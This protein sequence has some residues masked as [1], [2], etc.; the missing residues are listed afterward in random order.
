VNVADCTLVGATMDS[1]DPQVR[2]ADHT[3]SV[4]SCVAVPLLFVAE[5]VMK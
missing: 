3:S 2:T 4:N 5:K 1:H